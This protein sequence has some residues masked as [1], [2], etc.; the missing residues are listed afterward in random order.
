MTAT[1]RKNIAQYDAACI[2]ARRRID[3]QWLDKRLASMTP[4]AD[5]RDA[6]FAAAKLALAAQFNIPANLA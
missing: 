6:E 4:I 1:L 2:I 5:D 3:S